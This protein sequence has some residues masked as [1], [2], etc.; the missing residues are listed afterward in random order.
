MNRPKLPVNLDRLGHHFSFSVIYFNKQATRSSM[1][2]RQYATTEREARA[3]RKRKQFQEYYMV[4]RDRILAKQR[5]NNAIKYDCSCGAIV[6]NS[7]RDVHE[8]SA[9][10]MRYEQLRRQIDEL[11]VR[12]REE[13]LLASQQLH[14]VAASFLTEQAITSQ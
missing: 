14:C 10:H 1:S 8:A 12:L 5:Q 11:T 3:I 7:R 13:R 4:N 2:D 6:A 9:K